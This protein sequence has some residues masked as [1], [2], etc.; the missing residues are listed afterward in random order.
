MIETLLAEAGFSGN[1]SL[2]YGDLLAH[3][4]SGASAIAKRCGLSRSSVYTVLG[5]LISRGLVGTTHRNEIKQFV[6]EDVS[7]LRELSERKRKD[8]ER[9][10][11]AITLLETT[12]ASMKGPADPKLPQILSFEGQEGLK[13]IYLSMLRD[14]KRGSNLRILRDEFVWDP[15]WEFVFGAE[16]K[17]RVKRW[18]IDLDIRTRLLVNPSALEKSKSK[19][20]ASRKKTVTKYLPERETVKDFALYVIDDVA[21]ILSMEDGNLVGIRVTNRRIAENFASLFD[22]LWGKQRSGKKDRNGKRT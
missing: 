2:I 9:E 7:A 4:P 6:A 10:A 16:W 17:R 13:K 22:T 20:Y 12:I 8:M 19:F 18:K 14:A 5:V 21:S 3:S 1:E 11:K 15:A